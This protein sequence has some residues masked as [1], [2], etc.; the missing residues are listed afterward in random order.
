MIRKKEKK[1]IEK[2]K[3]EGININWIGNSS[4]N[5]NKNNSNNNNNNHLQTSSS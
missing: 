1:T 3:I 4:D 5:N 2:A